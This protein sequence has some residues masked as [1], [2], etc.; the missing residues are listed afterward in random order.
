MLLTFWRNFT[1]QKNSKKKN[2]F[3]KPIENN[4]DDKITIFITYL[5]YR[6][7]R[8]IEINIVI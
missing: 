6:D 5:T 8:S 4:F 3:V 2:T 7:F 1:N